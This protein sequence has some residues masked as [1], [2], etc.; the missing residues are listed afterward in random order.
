MINNGILIGLKKVI[1]VINMIRIL[2]RLK[3]FLNSKE[4]HIFCHSFKWAM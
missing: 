4:N 2:V 1:I 3:N